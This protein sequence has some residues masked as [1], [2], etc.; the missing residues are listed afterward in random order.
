[1]KAKKG[2]AVLDGA[3]I[4]VTIFALVMAVI[5]IKVNVIGPINED[6]Q[7]DSDFSAQSKQISQSNDTGFSN[8]WDI[9]VIICLFS[10]WAT[11]LMLAFKIDSYPVFFVFACIGIAIVLL[12]AIALEGTY[13]DVLEDSTY[14]GVELTFP[15]VHWLMQHIVVVI[16]VI[17]FSIAVVL[18]GKA[19]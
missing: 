1:M 11:A 13:N 8:N 6:I 3:V 17:S 2:N 7:A 10:L 16:M 19:G 4:L 5:I 15:Y 14:S 18:Y 9:T 12:V